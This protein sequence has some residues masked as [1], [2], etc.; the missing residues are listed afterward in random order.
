MTSADMTAL[1]WVMPQL[2]SV[3]PGA[4]DFGWL[5]DLTPKAS[6]PI[7]IG[8]RFSVEPSV[9]MFNIFNFANSFLG[10]NVPLAQLTPDPT[11]GLLAS[12]VVGGV[13][14]QNILPFRATFG[15][16]TYASGAPR[17][18]EFGLKVDF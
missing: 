8:E 2:P 3:A 16:G 14:R 9:S 18:F 10:G 5:K 17:Q 4:V 13:T 11:T 15:S 6:W 7:K 1:G 12:N